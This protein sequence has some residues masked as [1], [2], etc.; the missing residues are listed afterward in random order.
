M[1]PGEKKRDPM[2]EILLLI[3]VG[4]AGGML[5]GIVGLGGGVIIVPA[6]VYIMGY[7]QHLAQGTTLAMMLPPI[8]V[9]AVIQYY[10]KGHVDFKVAGILCCGFIIGA[11]FG[12][13]IAT[14]LP[15]VALKRVF[16][17]VLI[18]LAAKLILTK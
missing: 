18:L 5:S 3:L 12:S 7:N 17:A 16:G 15:E 8:G 2:T 4:I 13:K 6:L 14:G 9:L 1:N 10:N 11:F